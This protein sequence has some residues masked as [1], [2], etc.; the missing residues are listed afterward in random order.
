MQ[1]IIPDLY[2]GGRQDAEEIDEGF[3]LVVNC[4]PDIPQN[5]RKG[6]ETCTACR[7]LQPHGDDD[8]SA[9]AEHFPRVVDV[10]IETLEGR[11]W[12]TVRRGDRDR[13]L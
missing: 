5:E 11:Q 13:H 6:V 8:N 2:L 7:P 12:S 9:M 3:A 4:T 10:I 1:E